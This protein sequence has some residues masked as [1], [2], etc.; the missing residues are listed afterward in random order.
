[1][2]GPQLLLFLACGAFVL[3]AYFVFEV[4]VFRYSC[5]LARVP[6]P[7][8]LRSIAIVI[9]VLFAVSVAEGV[10]H[11]SISG[12]LIDGPRDGAIVGITIVNARRILEADGRAYRL[13]GQRSRGVDRSLLPRREGRRDP[14]AER[15]G[16]GL[17]R[18]EMMYV[19]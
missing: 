7:T 13:N 12:N 16:S 15:R 10:G 8:L 2:K 9:V 11:V 1:M 17:A 18:H 19:V 6:R 14:R 5:K 4:L 3:F